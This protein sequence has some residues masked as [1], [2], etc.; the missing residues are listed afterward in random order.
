MSTHAYM[1]MCANV[2]PPWTYLL[3]QV[4]GVDA[5]AVAACV[6]E[7]A[8]PAEACTRDLIHVSGLHGV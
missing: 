3:L 1:R 5:A 8:V 7:L 4:P 6:Q 2:R